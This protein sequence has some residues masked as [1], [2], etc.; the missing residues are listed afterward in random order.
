MPY[1]NW[2][3]ASWIGHAF[4]N[5]G[6]RWRDPARAGG[7][8]RRILHAPRLALPRGID[9]RDVPVRV[10][11]KPLAVVFQRGTRGLEVT[12]GLRHVLR[13]QQ[14]AHVHRG[15]R[16][17]LEARAP[18]DVIRARR[19]GEIV[20]VFLVVMMRRGA[21]TLVARVALDAGGA[22]EP[23]G[24]HGEPDVVG[25]E[26]REELGGRVELV[27]VPAGI[28]QHADLRK[29]LC[30]EVE[31]TDGAGAREGPRHPGGPGDLD[32][33][34]F[35]GRDGAIERHFQD[36]PVVRVAV[37]GRDKPHAGRDVPGGG[38]ANEADAGHINPAPVRF[39]AVDERRIAAAEA[40]LP[41]PR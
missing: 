37:V 10:R 7:E 12:V 29:P 14:Q 36:R 21:V 18:L 8:E 9:D 22:H 33:E 20:D 39:R 34:R 3:P 15:Q 28:L 27:A 17:M 30:H 11:T 26:V 23:A 2:W 19:P 35:P 32:V 40:P 5:G 4:W 16:R 13:L 24:R 1:Q 31:I 38:A 6:A 25:A 41:H